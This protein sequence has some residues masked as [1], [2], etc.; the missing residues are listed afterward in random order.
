MARAS[1]R[2]TEIDDAA[3]AESPDLPPLNESREFQE[4]P[5]L[6]SLPSLPPLPPLS[7]RA[8][9]GPRAS[10]ASHSERMFVNARDGLRLRSG[11]GTNFPPI[12]TLPL[13]TPLDVLGRDNEWAKIDLEGDGVA[14]GFV[15]ATFLRSLAAT[16]AAPAAAGPDILDQ[17]TPEKV[18]SI[19]AAATLLRNISA[20]LPFVIAGLRATGLGDKP[21]VL[22]SLGTIRAETE[23][24]RPISEGISSFN[25][26][27][28]PFDLYDAGT[29]IGR[30]LGNTQRGDGPAFKGRGFVQLTGRH[31]YTVIGS[32]IGQPLVSN[33]ELA[34]DPTIAGLILAT[35]LKNKERQIRA[36]LQAN[37]LR[38]ARRKVNGG[39]HGLSRFVDTFTRGQQVF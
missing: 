18:K 35:F 5:P 1:R 22:M 24:F 27:N 9:A 26:A 4:L 34:N 8:S 32:Q 7:P 21:M 6:P 14:D 23:G 17:V 38:K 31:N 15:L 28:S 36:A 37:D 16:I 20:N 12:R 19:F 10:A 29:T 11:P 25:T 2:V 3:A 33:P 13:N 39:V 30:K